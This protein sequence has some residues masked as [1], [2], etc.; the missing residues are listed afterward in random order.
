[1]PPD[2]P[3]KLTVVP[4]EPG[5]AKIMS[6]AFQVGY[7][8]TVWDERDPLTG[9]WEAHLWS[10][11]GCHE[12]DGETVTRLRLAEL[13]AELRRRLESDGPWWG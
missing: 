6:G 3:V 10:V 11:A 13:R 2:R 12:A 5:Y 7:A 8:L 4:V 9:A 1:M